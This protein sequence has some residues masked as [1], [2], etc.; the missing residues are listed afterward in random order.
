MLTEN[1]DVNLLYLPYDKW[2]VTSVI[3]IGNT[4]DIECVYMCPQADVY[5]DQISSASYFYL[6]PVG[7]ER[8]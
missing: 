1:T 4:D 3:C 8:F 5:I 7:S 6:T 2:H